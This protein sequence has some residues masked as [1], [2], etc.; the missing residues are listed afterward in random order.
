MIKQANKAHNGFEDGNTGRVMRL[1]PGNRRSHQLL[2]RPLEYSSPY[3]TGSL[4]WV[5]SSCR[6][7]SSISAPFFSPSQ[8]TCYQDPNN[9]NKMVWGTKGKGRCHLTLPFGNLSGGSTTTPNFILPVSV[10]LFALPVF[11]PCYKA[12]L[13]RVKTGQQDCSVWTQ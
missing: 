8:H 7:P 2:S 3:S 12:P 13:R 6:L 11:V 5:Y 1:V 4:L 10:R 9:F